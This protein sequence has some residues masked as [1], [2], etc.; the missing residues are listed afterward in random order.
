M[1]VSLRDQAFLNMAKDVCVEDGRRRKT[2]VLSRW[3]S[4]AVSFSGLDKDV[5]L[6]NDLKGRHAYGFSSAFGFL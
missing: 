4:L 1:P 3:D 2:G 6:S 5:D